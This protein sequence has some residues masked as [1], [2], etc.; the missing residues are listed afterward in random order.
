MAGPKKSSGKISFYDWG[1]ERGEIAASDISNSSSLLAVSEGSILSKV[2]GCCCSSPVNLGGVRSVTYK[3][4]LILHY[5][6]CLWDVGTYIRRRAISGG[7]LSCYRQQMVRLFLSS[8]PIASLSLSL[9]LPT[10]THLHFFSET[11]GSSS[12]GG[13]RRE[14]VDKE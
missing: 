12:S 5:T 9:S 10:H 6:R 11:N 14:Y 1:R 4:F 13:G 7:Y 8:R 2:V 3:E